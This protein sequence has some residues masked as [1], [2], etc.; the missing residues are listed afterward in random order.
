MPRDIAQPAPHTASTSTQPEIAMLTQRIV[1][2]AAAAF[3]IAT[4][5]HHTPASAQNDA[6]TASEGPAC[7]QLEVAGLKPGVGKL[8]VAAYASADQFFKQP[9]W[10][11]M[12][13]LPTATTTL[14]VCGFADKEL[15]FTAFQDLNGNGKLDTNAFGIPSEPYG[16]S[17]KP[18]KF[19]AP[20]FA[21][22]KVTLQAGSVIRFSM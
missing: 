3:L 16:A 21:D 12:V 4:N 18:P 2:F 6:K 22:T 19:S 17:G 13:D 10:V 20:T 15:A 8:M 11:N 5:A 1:S 7:A 9:A 14:S